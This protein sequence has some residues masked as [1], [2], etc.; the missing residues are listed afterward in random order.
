M[1]RYAVHLRER[2]PRDDS[3]PPFPVVA[4]VL[5]HGKKAFAR[6]TRSPDPFVRLRPRLPFFVDDLT[7][8]TENGLRSRGLTPLGTLT[9]L[10][11]ARLRG[12]D[13]KDALAAFD[14]WADLMRAAD[15]DEGPPR[16]HDALRVIG[17]H[18][19]RV[20][21]V[22]A[23]VLHEAF[24]RILQR[25][26]DTIMSTAEKLKHEGMQKGLEMGRIEGRVEGRVEGRLDT[27]LRQ[28]A[29]RFGP[30]DQDV[31]DRVRHGSST[32]L[33]RWT[34]RILEAPTLAAVFAS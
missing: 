34:D 3:T 22:P 29:K 24:E 25:P 32:D 30:L 14:R 6:P 20:A 17:Y 10:C 19:L 26:E 23:L 28:M 1:L 18:A 2:P 16:G 13:T 11:L 7:V 8:Q 5:H 33:D 21:E 12:L 31:V 27:L 15:R 4:V 9:F